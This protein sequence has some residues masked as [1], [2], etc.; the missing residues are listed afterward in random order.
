MCHT[1]S[2]VKYIYESTSQS[3]QRLMGSYALIIQN[4]SYTSNVNE[5]FYCP[6]VRQ[7]AC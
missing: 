4:R 2:H 1:P 5:P 6:Q 7:C 3:T